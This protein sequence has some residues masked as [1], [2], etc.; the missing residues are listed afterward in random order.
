MKI[1]LYA[2]IISLYC[3][4]YLCTRA[5]FHVTDSPAIWLLNSWVC[6]SGLDCP[7]KENYVQTCHLHDL[8]QSILKV[9]GKH[10]DNALNTINLKWP[11]H[12]P[13]DIMADYMD[14]VE[15]KMR[16]YFSFDIWSLGLA[17]PPRPCHLRAK[18]KPIFHILVQRHFW[19]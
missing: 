11:R 8:C 3:Y 9:K 12:M 18:N 5:V 13:P 1:F 2:L 10:T 17:L 16:K 19:T 14:V 4:I 15:L 6:C 7:L